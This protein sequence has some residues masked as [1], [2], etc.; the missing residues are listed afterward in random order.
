MKKQMFIPFSITLL[1]ILSSVTIAF[2][3]KEAPKSETKQKN[4]E[5]ELAPSIKAYMCFSPDQNAE[6]CAFIK[7]KLG[8]EVKQHFMSDGEIGAKLIAE[9]PRFSVDM[10]ISVGSANYYRAKKEG[11]IIP[12]PNSPT[13][14]GV[15]AVFKDPDNHFFVTEVSPLIFL[16][17]KDLLA[18]EGYEVP[19]SWD[20]LLDPK[21]KD[22]IVVP[23]PLTSGN[24]YKIIVAAMTLYGFNV[25]KGEE[26]GWEYLD[27]LDKNI[28][29][30]TRSGSAP[31]SLV[32]RKEFM[33]GITYAANVLSLIDQGYHIGYV[34]P[35][36]G[37]GYDA[38]AAFILKGTE[39]EYTCKKVIDLLGTKEFCE[40]VNSFGTYST[41]DPTAV[42]PLFAKAPNYIPNIDLKWAA[43]NHERLCD[44]WQGRYLM[45][46]EK[47]K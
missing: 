17:N 10:C 33:L 40:L 45:K 23:S 34:L 6:V 43:D 32:A 37:V 11:W 9:S 38:Y 41:K 8:V 28:N 24:G 26:G 35:K 13:W 27:A 21:W 44:E 25:D 39:N 22:Q 15:S 30:Y 14:Q 36:E 31:V 4:K 7:E 3:A 18:K 2:C 29:H 16:Y 1:L 20:D 12:Y 42:N 19:E 46:Q 47:K 5:E